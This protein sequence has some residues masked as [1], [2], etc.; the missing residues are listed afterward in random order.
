MRKDLILHL[1]GGIGNYLLSEHPER[2]VIAIHPSADGLHLCV[3]DDNHHTDE[4]IERMRRDLNS[5]KRPEFA[6]YYGA[7]TGHDLLGSTRLNLLGWQVKHS[8]VRRTR[9]GI[10]IDIWVGG[11]SFENHKPFVET[12]S[13]PDPLTGAPE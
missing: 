2:M 7:M 11:E 5:E 9:R 4:E 8:D 13:L 12:D 10:R 1:I 3:Q 6:A